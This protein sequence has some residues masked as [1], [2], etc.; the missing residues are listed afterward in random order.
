MHLSQCMFQLRLLSRLLHPILCRRM[1]VFLSNPPSL[2]RFHLPLFLISQGCYETAA[3]QGSACDDGVFCTL[4]T[5]CNNGIC[6]GGT[7]RTCADTAC[8]FA[9]TCSG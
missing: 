1:Y 9:G 2:S 6:G 8:R 5:L 4:N 3:N 7:I